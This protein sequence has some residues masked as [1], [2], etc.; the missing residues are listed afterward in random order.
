L[1]NSVDRHGRQITPPV[2]FVAEDIAYQALSY[3]ERLMGDSAVAQN[4]FEEAEAA[5]SEAVDKRKVSARP[6]I[7]DLRAYLFRASSVGSL[8]NERKNLPPENNP[9]CSKRQMNRHDTTPALK[10]QLLLD[11]VMAACDKVTQEIALRRIEGYSWDEIRN[12]YGLSAHATRLR[13]SKAL[14]RTRKALRMHGV[15]RKKGNRVAT[16][17]EDD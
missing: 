7:R 4:L 14:Q 3:A 2:L 16:F 9:S 15:G 11:E 8:S 1:V 5:V 12:R 10:T 13:F 17:Q 6:P